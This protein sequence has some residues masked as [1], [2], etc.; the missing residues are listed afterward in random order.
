MLVW[1]LQL[2]QA[3]AESPG[4]VVLIFLKI[5]SSLISASILFGYYVRVDNKRLFLRVV[6][7]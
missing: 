5:M 3:V 2:G 6:V 1:I 7:L 4:S